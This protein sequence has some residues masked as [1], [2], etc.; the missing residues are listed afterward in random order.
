LLR[1]VVAFVVAFRDDNERSTQRVNSA[2]TS[3]LIAFVTFVTFVTFVAV[4]VVLS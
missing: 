1:A 4:V 2:C 3:L